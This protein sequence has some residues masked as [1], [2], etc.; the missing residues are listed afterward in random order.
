MIATKVYTII[1]LT[2]GGFSH[3]ERVEMHDFSSKETC[4]AAAY[5]I[6]NH[7]I[8]DAKGTR[9]LIAFCKEN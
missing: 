1:V 5:A 8:S 3:G 2:W 7:K 9:N 6:N 4:E